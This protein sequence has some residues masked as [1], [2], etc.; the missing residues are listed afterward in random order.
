MIRRLPPPVA[1]AVS[2]NPVAAEILGRWSELQLPD[3]WLI[4]GVVVQSYW[5][6][7]HG[8]PPTHGISDIDLIY[9]DGEDLSEASEAQQ[10]SH[11]GDLFSAVNIPFDVK[12]EAR[13]HL[14]YEQRF[15]YSIPAYT[16][17][18]AAIATFP[19]TAGAIGIRPA[20]EHI[21]ACAPFGF[22]DLLQLVVRP[23]K[24]QV[25]A[26]IYNDKAT[27]WAS[28]WPGLRVVPW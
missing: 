8:L 25:T 16:S 28:I 12:N 7:R 18:E 21:E 10:V 14:W 24:R 15:G 23:N 13:V 3:A 1:A 9:F 26:E 20:G 4:A 6:A 27:R 5:N 2:A 11:V 22:D 19:T 17:A